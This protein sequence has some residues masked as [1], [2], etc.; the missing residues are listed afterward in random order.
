MLQKPGGLPVNDLKLQY[1]IKSLFRQ[2]VFIIAILCSIAIITYSGSRLIADRALL[3]SEG[4]AEEALS[5]VVEESSQLEEETVNTN[6]AEQTGMPKELEVIERVYEYYVD[7]EEGSHLFV[8]QSPGKE[9]KPNSDILGRFPGGL[10]LEV[11]DNH[12]NNIFID[13]FTWWEIS[14]PLS[15]IKGWVAAEYLQKRAIDS[16][17]SDD[18][19]KGSF[20]TGIATMDNGW[21]YYRSNDNGSIYK[22]RIDG[23]DVSKVNDDDSYFINVADN[24]VYYA[25]RDYGFNIYKVYAD[26]SKRQKINDYNYVT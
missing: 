15:E 24:W 8:R 14:D 9:G 17:L 22:I 12:G 18:A 19:S 13:N 3:R 11:I 26:G 25:N 16:G 1:D 21:V 2:P 6:G 5:S 7:V 20:K 10:K 23:N 4:L